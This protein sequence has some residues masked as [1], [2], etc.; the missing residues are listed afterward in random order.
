MGCVHLMCECELGGVFAGFW[1][2]HSSCCTVCIL[3]CALYLMVS[4]VQKVNL[5]PEYPLGWI[6]SRIQNLF[7]LTIKEVFPLRDMGK[8]ALELIFTELQL[9]SWTHLRYCN[10]Q[11]WKFAA[12]V[13]ECCHNT[14][15][16][17]WMKHR[18]SNT[19]KRSCKF[20][21]NEAYIHS[22]LMLSD[23]S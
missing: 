9:W 5:C 18:Q 1:C 15:K 6:S 10:F 17:I 12:H 19:V 16:G 2:F 7:H 21:P 20:C 22:L 11:Q 14:L 8:K 3:Q 4:R 23:K 13:F